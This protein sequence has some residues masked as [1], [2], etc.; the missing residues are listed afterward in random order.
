SGN[1]VTVGWSDTNTGNLTTTGPWNDSVTIVNT[2]TGATLRSSAVPFSGGSILPGGQAAQSYSFTLPD[3][4]AGGGS[5]KVV[6]TVNANNAE[7]E[8]NPAGTATGN[9]VSTPLVFPS[10]LANYADLIVQAGSLAVTPASPQSG[11]QVTVTWND[12]NQGNAAV[13]TP[14]YDYVLV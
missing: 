11:D 4:A 1:L 3:G 8:Y 5:L 7:A 10:T 9:N 13:N 6:V 12:Q 2:T 14:F